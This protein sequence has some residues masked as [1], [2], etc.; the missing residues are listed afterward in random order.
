MKEFKG[1]KGKWTA[2]GNEFYDEH[3]NNIFDIICYSATTCDED[4]ANAL[5][6]AAAPEMLALLQKLVGIEGVQ[7]GDYLWAR[8]VFSVIKKALGE[9]E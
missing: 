5:L 7:P 3:H 8:E 4:Y 9:D 6:I 2:E 1:T